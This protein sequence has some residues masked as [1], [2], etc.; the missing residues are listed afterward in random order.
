MS[1]YNYFIGNNIQSSLENAWKM[2][3]YFINILI[4]TVTGLILARSFICS[5][6]ISRNFGF[7]V[8]RDCFLFHVPMIVLFILILL[9]TN[10]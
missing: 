4:F 8:T 2:T 5:S 3:P 7:V 6:I 9:E 1:K 10:S